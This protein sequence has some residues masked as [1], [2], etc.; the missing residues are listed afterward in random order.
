MERPGA[1][2][3]GRG[4]EPQ[5]RTPVFDLMRDIMQPCIADAAMDEMSAER[6]AASGVPPREGRVFC[7]PQD[8]AAG[9]FWIYAED[10]FAVSATD[11]TFLQ[12]YRERCQH[13]RFVAI[14]YY[15]SGSYTIPGTEHT[16]TA[17]YLEGYVTRSPLWE[18]ICSA[19]QP[20]RTIDIMLAP[21]FYERYL[22]EVYRDEVFS[23]EEAFASIDG[24][25][26]FPEMIVL[27]EQMAAYRG[28]GASAR[29]FYRSKVE[30]AVALVVDKSRALAAHGLKGGV[31][32]EDVG[33]LSPEDR[34]AIERVRRHLDKDLAVQTNA[35]ELAH[36]ACM[37]QTKLRCAFKQACGCTIVE[38][39]QRRRCE[40]AAELLLV[41]DLPV[42][43]V[44]ASVGYRPE[45]LAELFSRLYG[46]TP[47]AYRTALARPS[48]LST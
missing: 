2:A 18:C 11:M 10:S 37:G 16:V 4:G 17:P 5:V 23:A 43:Q 24:I 47:S 1:P 40:R 41:S 34:R 21:P 39:R 48:A 45:R 20:L 33:R 9:Y 3:F 14:R 32:R 6:A 8:I 30:E 29:L 25:A 7:L 12:D 27:L 46:T 42:S 28:R 19:D 44:A 35:A 26:D 22:R 36:I 13:P 31:S 15:R 38:Y